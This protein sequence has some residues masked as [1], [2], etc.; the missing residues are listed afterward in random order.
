MTTPNFD[1]QSLQLFKVL[2][3]TNNLSK[4]A[5]ILDIP[6]ATASRTLTRL[7]ETLGDPLFTR[8]QNGLAPTARSLSLADDVETI[9]AGFEHLTASP[10]FDPKTLTREFKIAA[11]DNA[12]LWLSMML[13]DFMKAAPN[14]S[15]SVLPLENSWENQLV[16]GELDAIIS[17]I[18][19]IPKGMHSLVLQ[20]FNMVYVT[21]N[22]HPL[23]QISRT[24]PVEPEELLQYGAIELTF[25]PSW[26]FHKMQNEKHD[27]E[28]KSQRSVVRLPYFQGAAMMAEKSDLT[29]RIP[30][31]MAKYCVRTGG[32]SVINVNVPLTKISAQLIWYERLHKDPAMQWLRSVIVNACEG[33]A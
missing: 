14:A 28:G 2:M 5:E 10:V 33:G 11:V 32:L 30:E 7:R 12:V 27:H 6:I 25:R 9:L 16:A 13:P 26:L 22:T 4:A 3:Q 20:S 1:R 18:P 17:P 15:F 31:P 23:A 24:R 8:C 19:T 21:R 29:L